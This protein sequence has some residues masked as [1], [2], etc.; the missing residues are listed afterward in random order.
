MA[1]E[2]GGEVLAIFLNHVADCCDSLEN[3]LEHL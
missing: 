2:R 1:T 3:E